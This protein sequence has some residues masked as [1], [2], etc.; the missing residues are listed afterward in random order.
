LHNSNN[1]YNRNKTTSNSPLWR[2][3]WCRYEIDRPNVKR[4]GGRWGGF[5]SIKFSGTADNWSEDLYKR[6]P[7]IGQSGLVRARALI[8][9]SGPEDVRDL[10]EGKCSRGRAKMFVLW[11]RRHELLKM[12]AG[13]KGVC[14]ECDQ[15][16]AEIIGTDQ[17]ELLEQHKRLAS[18][19]GTQRAKANAIDD[20]ASPSGRAGTVTVGMSAR[21]S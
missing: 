5:H 20:Y 3:L 11:E 1:K 7:Q 21:L 2:V 12:I 18:K 14:N 4:A 13:P 16:C 15:L 9:L 17:P 6:A 19:I 8:W 10:L